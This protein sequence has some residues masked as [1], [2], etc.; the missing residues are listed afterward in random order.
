[1]CGIWGYVSTDLTGFGISREVAERCVRGLGHRG[2][3][4]HGLYWQPPIALGHTRLAIVDRTAAASQPMHSPD[5]R[6]V[7]LFN[8]EVYNH[9]ELRSTLVEHG[10]QFM[11][12]GD[13]EVVLAAFRQWGRACLT[14][15]R[16]M[17]AIVVVDKERGEVWLARDRLGIKPLYVLRQPCRIAFSSELTGLLT[18]LDGPPQIDVEAVSA[19]LTLRHVPAPQTLVCGI[20]QLTAGGDM[21]WRAGVSTMRT[22][23]EPPR[24]GSKHT[25][26]ASTR[27]R[28]LLA[29][30]VADCIGSGS[31]LSC[32]LS[33]GLDSSAMVALVVQSTESVR[34]LTAQYD[35]A[36]SEV[37]FARKV[38]D[39]F[40][41]SLEV[42]AVDPTGSTDE[43][44]ATAARC[45][46][47]IALHNEVALGGLAAAVHR[48]GGRVALSGEGADELFSGYGRLSRLP[49]ERLKRRVLHPLRRR[50][51]AQRPRWE[52]HVPDRRL[53]TVLE[54]YSYI[55][56]D[57]KFVLFRASVAEGL[58][59][60]RRLLRTLSA[61][62][63]ES[64]RSSM[65]QQLRRFLVRIHLPGLL[66]ALD[67]SGMAWGVETRFPYLDHRLVE[68]SMELP[69]RST[70][71]WR[72]VR[73]HRAAWRE[74]PHEYSERRDITKVALRDAFVGD[75]PADVITRSKVPFSA[76]LGTA[77]ESESAHA[78][79]DL[80]LGPNAR[81]AEI[82][83]QDKLRSWWLEG[84]GDSERSRDVFGR[85][86]WLIVALELWL[87]VHF[88]LG[89]VRGHTFRPSVDP[90]VGS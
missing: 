1:M 65:H 30:G 71:R 85:R 27:T 64:T 6:H 35:D 63:A 66:R 55:P 20:E 3:D 4:G 62:W 39:R 51:S 73:D 17:F 29:D 58:D 14:R 42:I 21:T 15:L 44:L 50:R 34:L 61:V 22:W 36:A 8:G 87:R 41:H 24:G 76:P 77:L 33:G 83:D 10:H 48:G 37:T 56:F 79:R 78:L 54:Q 74:S 69:A 75:L 26:R 19:Y 80:V 89:S 31:T 68:W 12:I 84:A 18:L 53:R 86:A 45:D 25:R 82:L 72:S 88:P 46:H 57:L 16:G 90:G 47:P 38:A 40:G 59:D 7:L 32:Y 9:N 52:R 23:W 5:G 60:D 49:F 28:E 67:S 13:T 81:I 43:L 2:P 70:L 11:G